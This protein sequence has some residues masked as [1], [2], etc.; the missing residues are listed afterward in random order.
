MNR[1][2]FVRILEAFFQRWYLYVLPAAA[3]ALLGVVS[4]SD[5][6]DDFSSN[7]S[8]FV[9]TESLVTSRTG[10]QDEGFG[11]FLT[12]AEFTSQ[13]LNG[14]L[15]TDS[16]IQS[17]MDTAGIE[18][19]AGPL[20]RFDQLGEVRESITS[21]AASENL[22]QVD[23]TTPDPE[24]SQ[25][26]VAA[27]IDEFIEFRIGLDVAESERAE[28]LFSEL[29]DGYRQDFERARADVDAQLDGVVDLE[30]LPPDQELELERLQEEEA[31]AAAQ[32][33]ATLG[34]IDAAQVAARQAEINVGQ[35]FTLVDPP[36]VP[37]SGNGSIIDQILVL[38]MYL[39]VGIVLAITGPVI[40]AL[41][42]RRV[43]FPDDLA[44]LIDPRSIAI[45]PGVAK[46]DLALQGAVVS[47]ASS[48]PPPVPAPPTTHDGF[49]GTTP[50]RPEA[51]PTSTTESSSARWGGSKL[52]PSR[53]DPVADSSHGH[54]SPQENDPPRRA[55][56]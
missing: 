21:W 5:Q 31:R 2:T 36:L 9:D 42:S 7:G 54:H 50:L 38:A 30:A 46:G 27:A 47:E 39:I 15:Q 28:A 26:L 10:V 45:L 43:L 51:A 1:N 14:L 35:Q 56:G 53:I 19:N 33:S 8:V 20:F 41:L 34:S 4:V 24:L 48:V 22:M 6:A 18:A 13:E 12:P 32:L 40:A 17:V 44:H 16:F 52:S 11:S 25:R 49:G 55:H 37:T 3:M 23:A 29:A